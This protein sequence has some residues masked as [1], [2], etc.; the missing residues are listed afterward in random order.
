MSNE[1]GVLI[2]TLMVQ[3][4]LTQNQQKHEQSIQK[5]VNYYHWNRLKLSD[6]DTD[7]KNFITIS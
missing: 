6:Y 1:R 4:S 3:A 7:I 5:R 2:L